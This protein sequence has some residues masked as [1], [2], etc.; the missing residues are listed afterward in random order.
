M[1]ARRLQAVVIG[2]GAPGFVKVELGNGN[3][4]F[5]VDV[6]TD[7]LP[8]GLRFPNAQF[9]VGVVVGRDL[10]SVESTGQEWLTIQEQ[11]RAVLM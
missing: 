7:K 1:G 2:F 3:H 6:A 8:P 10:L 9:V 4:Q 5:I 11:I